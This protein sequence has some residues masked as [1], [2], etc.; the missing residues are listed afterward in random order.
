MTKSGLFLCFCL[1][2]AGIAAWYAQPYVGDNSD[3]VLV[4]TTVF[5]VFAG[6][7][8]AII[9]ILGD[10]SLVP[11][12]SWQII[13]NRREMIEQRIIWHIY[14]LILYLVTIALIFTS[15]ILRKVPVGIVSEAAKAWIDRAYLFFGIFSFLLSFAL[16]SALHRTQ[17]NRLNEETE[18]RRKAVGLRDRES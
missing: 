8:V 17:M 7:L 9:T 11:P 6:F 2:V 14:L 12:G 1:A 15:V 10:P 16:P 3:V 18:R 4:V 13:E 5:T